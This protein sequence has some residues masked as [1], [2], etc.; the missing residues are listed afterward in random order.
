[1][2][3]SP[4]TFNSHVFE[5][6]KTG[7]PIEWIDPDAVSVIDTSVTIAKNAPH[8]H[9]AMLMIDFALS[10]PGQEIYMSTGYNSPRAD[11]QN[12]GTVPKKKLYLGSRP[13]FLS[14]FEQW[15]KLYNRYIKSAGKM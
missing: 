3:F 7:A 13:D 10:K 4:T 12:A 1:V 2:P 5:S 14:E 8:P 6:K 15:G 11:I 9:A